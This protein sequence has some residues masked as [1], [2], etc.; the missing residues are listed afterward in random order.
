M[1]LAK[2][3]YHNYYSE[4][5]HSLHVGHYVKPMKFEQFI[6][7]FLKGLLLPFLAVILKVSRASP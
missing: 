6:L 3:V 2:F 4:C 7:D 5:K 1:I